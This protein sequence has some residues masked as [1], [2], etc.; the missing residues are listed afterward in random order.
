MTELDVLTNIYNV[1]ISILS[2]IDS[3]YEDFFS[4]FDD[5]YILLDRYLPILPFIGVVIIGVIVLY[6]T[7]RW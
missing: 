1:L 2:S 6:N 5:I 7:L 3:I 4:F